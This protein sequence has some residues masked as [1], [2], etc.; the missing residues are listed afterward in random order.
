MPACRLCQLANQIMLSYYGAY[1][2]NGRPS[3]FSPSSIGRAAIRIVRSLTPLLELLQGFR[4][5]FWKWSRSSRVGTLIGRGC[6]SSW[7]RL[8]ALEILPSRFVGPAI[9]ARTTLIP[10]LHL[11]CWILTIPRHLSEVDA[12][13]SFYTWHKLTRIR[14]RLS[15]VTIIKKMWSHVTWKCPSI[16]WLVVVVF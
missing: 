13:S 11:N 8:L 9:P 6:K 15:H 2:I 10:Q 12:L 5:Q 1:I 4:R 7:G 3:L 14:T 16:W